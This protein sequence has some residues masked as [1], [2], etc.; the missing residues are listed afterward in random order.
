MHAHVRKKQW[1][2]QSL[3][4]LAVLSE[5]CHGVS[6]YTGHQIGSQESHLLVLT[7]PVTLSKLL[8]LFVPQFLL[9]NNKANGSDLPLLS[10]L[11][12][13]DGS[14]EIRARDIMLWF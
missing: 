5:Y 9:L 12:S 1:P 14:K 11:R 10:T 7:L 3:H 13:A 6:W 2:L 8:D 4:L